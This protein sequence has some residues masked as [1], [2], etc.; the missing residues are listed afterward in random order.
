MNAMTIQSPT[1][2]HP[3]PLRLMT[4]FPQPQQPK[5]A[6]A[7]LAQCLITQSM[8]DHGPVIATA[9]IY[10]WFVP[11]SRGLY[12]RGCHVRGCT[13]PSLC[14]DRRAASVILALRPGDPGQ[15]LAFSIS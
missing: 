11:E 7:G 14:G 13:G 6:G 4:P 2:Q 1:I 5:R 3:I 15:K 12:Q 10:S 8:V 9:G